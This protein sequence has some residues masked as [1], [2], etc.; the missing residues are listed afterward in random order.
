MKLLFVAADVRQIGGIKKYNKDFL[1]ALELAGAEVFFIERKIGSF[2]QKA[3]FIFKVFLG[4]IKH[5]PDL[6]ICTH[7]N[8]LPLCLFLRKIFGTPY[9]V[10]LYGIDALDIKSG[11]RL[12]AV[13]E[14]EM[15]V[16][17]SGYIKNKILEQLP[18]IEEKIFYLPS[19]VDGGIFFIKESPEYLKERYNFGSDPIIVTIARLNPNEFKGY[20]KVAEAMPYVLKEIPNAKY[21]VVGSG[22]DR[23]LS[24]LFENPIIKN[25]VILAGPAG[26]GELADFYNLAD[27]FVMPSKIEGFGIV[28]I[29]ALACGRPVI[30]SDGYGCREGLLNGELGLLVNPDNPEDIAEA[31][32]KILKKDVPKNLLNRRWIRDRSLSVYGIEKY[33]SRVKDFLRILNK[34]LGTHHTRKLAVVMS[35]AIQYQAPLL[36]KIAANKDIDLKVY[37]NWDFGVKETLDTQFGRNVKWDTPLL[38]GYDY[39]FLKNFSPKPSS[40]FWGQI[41]FGIIPELVKNHYDSVLLFGWN[42][43]TNWLVFLVAP[44]VGTR[45]ILQGES[46]LSHE[47]IKKGPNRFAKRLIFRVLFSLVSKFL[48]IGGE[49]RKFYEYYGVPENKLIFAPYAV[50]NDRLFI[51]AKR[52][53]AEKE[54]FKREIG[55]EKNQPVI[56]FVGKFIEKKRPMDLIRAYELIAESSGSKVKNAALVFVG[57]GVLRSEMEDYIK[58]HNLKNVRILGFKNQLELPKFYALADIFVLPSGISETWGLVTNEAMCF[59][60]PVIVSDMVGCGADLIKSGE[61]GFIFPTG[62][63]RRLTE[64]I[65]ALIAD[66]KL[67]ANFGEKSRKIIETYSHETDVE[68]IIEAMGLENND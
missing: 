24:S 41:N 22:E 49:N 13:V 14:A 3:C 5:R 19:A 60:L 54:E 21:L 44:I 33:Q 27:V 47:L 63:I 61:N 58:T 6:I 17:I 9:T 8:F 52:L 28:F 12:K 66:A 18:E 1:E 2:W 36:R 10:N 26:D 57:D 32:I 38:E 29:E 51:S 35:H 43:F 50:E 40:D 56:L 31:I 65:S 39:K 11:F 64:C 37:F 4:E 59:G 53:K 45:I 46:P 20:Y 67:R 16:I 34:R 48:Y 68:A 23:R 55:I 62:D 42:Q 15:V 30:A 25:S 7:I